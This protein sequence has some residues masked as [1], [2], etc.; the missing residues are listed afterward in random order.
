MLTGKKCPDN[1]RAL[2]KLVEE[3]IRSFFQT[4]N[5]L[6]MDDLQHA[7]NDTVMHTVEQPSYG[8]TV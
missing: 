7:L 5:M 3:L 2:R 8:S 1:V 6:C 4:Q